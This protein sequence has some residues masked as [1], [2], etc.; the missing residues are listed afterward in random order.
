MPR[1]RVFSGIQPTADSF[2][3]GNYLGAIRQW[4]VLQDTHEAVYCVVDLH[5]ITVPQDPAQVV[6]QGH[7]PQHPELAWVLG[8]LTGFGEASRMTQFKDKAAKG[9]AQQ[10]SLGLFS[11]P[12]LQAADILLY[13]TN[14]V[15][16]G[17]DQRQHLELSRDLATRFN[18]RYGPTFTVPAAY[19]LSGVAKIN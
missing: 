16:V 8:C 2:H 3:L 14:E 9:G 17:E 18:H 4:V 6:V 1:P 10:A 13:Q 5:A 11:Y 15:P 19:I 12:V 7:L